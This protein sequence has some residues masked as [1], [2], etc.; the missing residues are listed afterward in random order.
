MCLINSTSYLFVSFYLF[1]CLPCPD[2]SYLF[3]FIL[4]L[5]S[6]IMS[7]FFYLVCQACSPAQFYWWCR[8][9]FV[10]FSFIR[11]LS[12][13]C[14]SVICLL[15]WTSC[16]W[17]WPLPVSTSSK[18]L[19]CYL[20]ASKLL[21]CSSSA[22][23]SP[24]LHTDSY[25]HIQFKLCKKQNSKRKSTWEIYPT[26]HHCH[27]QFGQTFECVVLAEANVMLSLQPQAK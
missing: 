22:P 20:F 2:W 9:W 3:L 16:F 8:C 15:C 19:V 27:Q 23:V 13:V 5:S 7:S 14:T 1:S 26:M 21:Q 12:G 4:P 18:P 25:I 24:C 10:L 17:V 11:L 6:L